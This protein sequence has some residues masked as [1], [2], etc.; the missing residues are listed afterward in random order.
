MA[1]AVHSPGHM[2]KV[3]WDAALYLDSKANEE[4][5]NSL[6]QIFGGHAGGHPAALGPHIGKVLGVKSVDFKYSAD[7]KKRS[8]E[9]PNVAEAEIEAIEGQGGSQVTISNHPLCIAPGEAAVVA[10]SKK[11]RYHDHGMNWQL[12]EKTGFY[13]PFSYKGP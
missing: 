5:K 3:K 11:L 1:L 10:K 7:G 4:Q 13:S 12:S 9:I 2:A 6:M 8:L